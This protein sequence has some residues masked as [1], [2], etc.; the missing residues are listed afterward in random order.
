M[1]VVSVCACV[2]LSL[3]LSNP[4]SISIRSLLFYSSLLLNSFVYL[5]P[6]VIPSEFRR[7][8]LCHKMIK[9]DSLDYRAALFSLSFR[10]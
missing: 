7:D 9:L 8:L 2:C 5:P 3:F 6:M 1:V 4:R 10:L